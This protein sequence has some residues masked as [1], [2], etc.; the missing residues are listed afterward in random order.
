MGEGLQSDVITFFP[1]TPQ[2]T[3]ASIFGFIFFNQQRAIYF[4][5][6]LYLG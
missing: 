5:E 3:L 2:V 6:F 1:H 4:K